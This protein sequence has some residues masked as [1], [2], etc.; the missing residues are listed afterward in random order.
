MR[1]RRSTNDSPWKSSNA[2]GVPMR[3]EAPAARMMPAVMAGLV[4]RTGV[5]KSLDTARM[6]AC[7][8]SLQQRFGALVGED[9][10][11]DRF[12]IGLRG[13]AHGYHFGHYRDRDLFG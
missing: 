9:G 3:R 5:E 8:T 11:G 12:P 1:M 7:A 10:F 13:A 6:S 2:F 4:A